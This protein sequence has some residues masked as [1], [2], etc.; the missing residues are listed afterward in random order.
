[1]QEVSVSN[2]KIVNDFLVRHGR[3]P[4]DGFALYG[5][6]RHYGATRL[7]SFVFPSHIGRVPRTLTDVQRRGGRGTP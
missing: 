4:L 5:F 1:V 6:R 3:K 7:P 2:L